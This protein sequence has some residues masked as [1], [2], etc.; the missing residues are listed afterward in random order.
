MAE[1]K[2][3]ESVKKVTYIDFDPTESY[4]P[5]SR[6][7]LMHPAG[8]P[9]CSGNRIYE[10][11]FFSRFEMSFAIGDVVKTSVEKEFDGTLIPQFALGEIAALDSSSEESLGFR[12]K[13]S[14]KIRFYRVDEILLVEK[15]G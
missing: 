14:D 3:Q 9:C 4:S 12:L 5:F 8:C 11:R 15:K 6:A 2:N 1:N 13:G 7:S 10:T